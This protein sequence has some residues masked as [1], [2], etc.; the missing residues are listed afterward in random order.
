[1]A[2]VRTCLAAALVEDAVSADASDAAHWALH[3]YIFGIQHLK[4]R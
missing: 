1:M 2:R 4:I 3:D